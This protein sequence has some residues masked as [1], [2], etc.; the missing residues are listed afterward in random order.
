MPLCCQMRAL[1]RG[2]VVAGLKTNKIGEV[3]DSK[4]SSDWLYGNGVVGVMGGW[5]WAVSPIDDRLVRQA[6]QQTFRL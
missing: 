5:G 6:L 1:S 4:E 2:C 3:I